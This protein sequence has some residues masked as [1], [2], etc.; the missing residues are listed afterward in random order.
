METRQDPDPVASEKYVCVYF[1]QGSWWFEDE[2]N[3]FV[4]PYGDEDTAKQK[5]DAYCKEELG[6]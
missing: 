3:N 4:G 5:F 2:T 1:Y 6:I